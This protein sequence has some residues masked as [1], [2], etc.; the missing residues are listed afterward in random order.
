MC[1]SLGPVLKLWVYLQNNVI[2]LQGGVNGRNN[3]LA[4]GVVERVVDHVG[5]DTVTRGDIAQRGVDAAGDSLCRA[6]QQSDI[7]MFGEQASDLDAMTFEPRY[8]VA[9]KRLITTR[10]GDEERPTRPKAQTASDVAYQAVSVFAPLVLALFI[11]AIIWPLQHRLQLHMP[12]L[13][14]LAITIIITI[15][16][17][18][19]FG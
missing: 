6:Q 16:I 4:K 3:T 1:E 9:V 18:L 17:G 14:A 7:E 10:V 13:V 15:F 5:Q 12:K 11:M 19:A 8:H 2:L